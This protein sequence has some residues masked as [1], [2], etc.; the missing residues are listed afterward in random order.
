MIVVYTGG[1]FDVLHKG[2]LRLLKKARSLGDY[3]VVGIQED[4]SVIK[5]KPKPV[6]STQERV[7]QMLEIPFVDKVVVYSATQTPETIKQIMPDVFVHGDDWLDQL[8]RTKIIQ[9][10]EN[11]NIK[12]VLLPRTQDISTSE[13]KRRINGTK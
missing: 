2:H 8:D 1:V 6:L 10:M 12:M 13:I 5:T 11:N 3:L 9:F 7:D 4:S